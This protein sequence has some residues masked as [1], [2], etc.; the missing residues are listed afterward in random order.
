MADNKE[1]MEEEVEVLEY[2]LTDEDGNESKFELIGKI[3]LDGNEY[4]A[5]L[6][7]GEDTEEFVILKCVMED[8]ELSFDT[9][10]DDEEFDKVADEFEDIFMGDF[11]CDEFGFSVEE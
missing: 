5:L 2:T 10:V 7:V 6:P 9:I 8:G 3:E 1:F 11:D 4:V